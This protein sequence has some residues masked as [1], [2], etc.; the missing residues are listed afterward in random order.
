MAGTPLILGS[1][2]STSIMNTQDSELQPQTYS[3]F[4][5]LGDERQQ[6]ESNPYEGNCFVTSLFKFR[7]GF[8]GDRSDLERGCLLTQTLSLLITCN[9]N[10]NYLQS[11]FKG[12]ARGRHIR[13]PCG[14]A[15]GQLL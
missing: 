8:E 5:L 13:L 12:Q 15:M 2:T 3:D 10:S 4:S 1:K 11:L 6:E 14:P 9:D 7:L